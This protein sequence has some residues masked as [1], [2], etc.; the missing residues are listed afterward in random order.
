MIVTRHKTHQVGRWTIGRAC[1]ESEVA[2][3]EAAVAEW[4]ETDTAWR[5]IAI[6]EAGREFLSNKGS[7]L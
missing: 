7:V 1:Y 2:A 3:T 6:P 4:D 5:L